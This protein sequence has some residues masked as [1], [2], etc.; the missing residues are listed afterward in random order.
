M[1]NNLSR[2]QVS[3]LTRIASGPGR[4]AVLN[5]QRR[6]VNTTPSYEG[7][8]PLNWFENTFLAVGSAIVALTDPRRAGCHLLLGWNSNADSL[9]SRHGCC[10]WRDNGWG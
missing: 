10:T 3:A 6:K 8:I 1:L 9:L 2:R 7:H 4:V 5:T